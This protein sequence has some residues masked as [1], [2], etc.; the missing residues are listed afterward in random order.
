MFANTP[1]EGKK[2][3]TNLVYTFMAH[4]RLEL[5]PS[6]QDGRI[7]PKERH[8]RPQIRDGI[9]CRRT[10]E[11]DS[12]LGIDSDIDKRWCPRSTLKAFYVVG[13]IENQQTFVLLE[14]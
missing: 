8:L 6:A 12:P 14:K 1:V 2:L 3:L 9:G 5:F 4:S 10:R 13:F 7:R 11:Y